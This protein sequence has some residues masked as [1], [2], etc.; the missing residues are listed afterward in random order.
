M[1]AHIK[2]R[3]DGCRDVQT[4]SIPLG[5]PRHMGLPIHSHTTHQPSILP[6]ALSWVQRLVNRRCNNELTPYPTRYGS[7]RARCWTCCV[8]PAGTSQHGACL[9]RHLRFKSPRSKFE[10]VGGAVRLGFFAWACFASGSEVQ[11]QG[12]D[13]VLTE[14]TETLG[15]FLGFRFVLLQRKSVAGSTSMETAPLRLDCPEHSV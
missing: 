13:P 7:M 15:C 4:C 9:C 1:W 3:K 12:A 6:P 10:A 8:G 2:R 14:E 11:V 5:M